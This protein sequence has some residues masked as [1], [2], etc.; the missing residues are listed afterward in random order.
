MKNR[1]IYSI[2]YI[3]SE[4]IYLIDSRYFK[5]ISLHGNQ[6]ERLFVWSGLFVYR[7]E[8]SL[9]CLIHFGNSIYQLFNLIGHEP[10]LQ[11]HFSKSSVVNSSRTQYMKRIK[12]NIRSANMRKWEH[13]KE[14]V[15]NVYRKQ[16]VCQ[17]LH[18]F[19]RFFF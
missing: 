7:R 11:F 8:I 5:S 3:K 19:M 4:N 16:M 15:K 18:F 13:A 2:N 10:L 12:K 6:A 14:T 17:F 1:S 9:P